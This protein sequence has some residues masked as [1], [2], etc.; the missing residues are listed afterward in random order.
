M[1]YLKGIGLKNFRNFKEYKYINFAPITLLTGANNTGKS[2]IFKALLLLKQTC[3]TSPFFKNLDFQE[4]SHHLGDLNDVFNNKAEEDE[5]IVIALPCS[6]FSRTNLILKLSIPKQRNVDKPTINQLEIVEVNND[7]EEKTIIKIKELEVTEDERDDEKMHGHAISQNFNCEFDAV[8]LKGVSK[9]VLTYFK[10][11]EK[12]NIFDIVPS[13]SPLKVEGYKGLKHPA[14]NSAAIF[15]EKLLSKPNEDLEKIKEYYSPILAN[16]GDNKNY[17][18]WEA[19]ERCPFHL[20]SDNDD[21]LFTLIMNEWETLRKKL[22]HVLVN[23]ISHLSS[24]RG[25]LERIYVGNQNNFNKLVREF[26]MLEEENNHLSFFHKW[27]YKLSYGEFSYIEISRKAK[28]NYSEVILKKNK[29]DD[30]GI[31]LVDLGYGISQ[32]VAILL[33][34]VVEA[35]KSKNKNAKSYGDISYNPSIILIEEPEANLHPKLQSQLTELFIDA[36]KK[37]RIQFI[38]E[39]HSEYLIYKFQESVASKIIEPTDVALHYLNRTD[40]NGEYIKH[41]PISNNGSID[42][43][44]FDSGFFDV[45]ADLRLSLLN[46]QRDRFVDLFESNKAKFGKQ[47]LSDE[48][49][50]EELGS[51]IDEHFDKIDYKTYQKKVIQDFPN[52]E[53]LQDNSK[54]YLASAYHLMRLYD[55]D[56]EVS[57]YSAAVIQFGRAVECEV[58]CLFRSAK[59]YILDAPGYLTIW[60]QNRQTNNNH[61]RY[62]NELDTASLSYDWKHDFKNFINKKNN[63]KY[64]ISFGES[65]HA[66]QLMINEDVSELN[67]VDILRVFNDYLKD[68]YFKNWDSIKVS[69]PDLSFIVDLRNKAAHTYNDENGEN[70]ILKNK[71][72][73]YEKEVKKLLNIWTQEMKF[74]PTHETN[75]IT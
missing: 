62:K 61:G 47:G 39:T 44:I 67:K 31:R 68:I 20:I 9:E 3:M 46:I 66:I 51:F 36:F 56:D 22:V 32:V 16:G 54:R 69:S 24:V 29:A 30:N 49:L 65:K 23:K 6:L 13:F 41:I 7:L 64:K 59:D 17:T 38:L 5:D 73:D 18:I 28:L 58:M 33:K 52:H 14:N 37:F 48:E 75:N 60:T 12:F 70:R 34:I 19:F 57:D 1:G 50:L 11:G 63:N 21:G 26:S 53:L 42:Y 35:S 27:I 72:D 43:T 25:N 15:I 8:W 2:S 71:A 4:G 55:E 74:K 10:E 45:Q 40:P